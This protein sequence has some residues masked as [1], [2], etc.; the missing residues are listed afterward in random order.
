MADSYIWLEPDK[1]KELCEKALKAVETERERRRW[2]LVKSRRDRVNNG[3]F[4]KLFKLKDWT[5]EMALESLK[6]EEWSQLDWIDR[7]WRDNKSSA[8]RLSKAADISEDPVLVSTKDY[9]RISIS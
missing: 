2:D 3:F 4:H 8:K 6:N 9:E 1:V 5:A 7:V